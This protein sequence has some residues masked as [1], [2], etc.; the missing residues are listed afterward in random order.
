MDAAANRAS[1]RC[2]RSDGSVQDQR[3]RSRGADVS[4]KD[5]DISSPVAK[6]RVGMKE[7][8]LITV[9]YPHD[10]VTI[11]RI[12]IS[13]HKDLVCG[14]LLPSVRNQRDMPAESSSVAED[15]ILRELEDTYVQWAEGEVLRFGYLSLYHLWERQIVALLED[16]LA[17]RGQPFKRGR[18]KLT[19]RVRTVLQTE[20]LGTLDDSIWEALDRGRRI[21]NEIKH[22]M[23]SASDPGE[24]DWVAISEEEFDDLVMS[25]ERFWD[26]IPY[27]VD[28]STCHRSTPRASTRPSECP[29]GEER[30]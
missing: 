24:A 9:V 23:K 16:Q 30:S 18:D 11:N 3:L 15:A 1:L 14:F 5:V 12:H 8:P 19:T 22:G 17:R 20:F 21:A 7:P 6:E 2:Q 26:D 27:K 4:A 29:P 13:H 28:Y 10:Q 25:L